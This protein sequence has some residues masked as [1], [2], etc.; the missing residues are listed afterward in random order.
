MINDGLILG[1]AL[2]TG[3]LLGVIFFGGLWWT[4]RKGF[5]PNSRHFGSSA[6]SCYE[7]ASPWPA[8]TL[9]RAAIGRDCW[10]ASLDLPW[11]ALS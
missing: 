5:R 6:A 9:S 7:R 1:L 11:R 10:C 4:I 2:V 3:A 8:S